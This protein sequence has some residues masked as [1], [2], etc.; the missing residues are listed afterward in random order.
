MLIA[1][2]KKSYWK[3]TLFYEKVINSVN[4]QKVRKTPIM[5]WASRNCFRTDIPE[6]KMKQQADALGSTGLSEFGYEYF[7]MDDGVLRQGRRW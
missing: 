5:G 4:I 3:Y 6:G 1:I 2:L 7:N